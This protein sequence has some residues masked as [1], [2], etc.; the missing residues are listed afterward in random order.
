[1]AND[2]KQDTATEQP[3]TPQK[4]GS[5]AWL[6]VLLLIVIIGLAGWLGYRYVYQDLLATNQNLQQQSA[7]RQQQLEQLNNELQQLKQQQQRLPQ[8]IEQN[9]D[10]VANSLRRNV[11]DQAQELSD[12]QRAVQSVQAE[13]AALDVSQATAWRVLE[14]RHLVEQASHKL[15]IDQQPELAMQL[16]ELADSHLAALNNP[17]YQGIRQAINDDKLVLATINT[18]AHVDTAMALTSL[19]AQL[20]SQRWIVS[21]PSRTLSSTDVAAD[22]P[23]YT[24]LQASAQTLFNQL[25]RVQHRERPIEPQLSMAFVELTKQRVLLQLQ[26]AQ[27][28]ALTQSDQLYRDSISEAKH[29][30]AE[31][32]AQSDIDLS[33][34]QYQLARLAS[35]QL[36]AE[37]PAQLRSLPLINQKARA[38]TAG[39]TP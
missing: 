14:A 34:L 8:Q 36:Q 37:L 17:A 21:A 31:V 22:A 7:Q 15:Y 32:A 11:S 6:V 24:R 9:L 30:V 20:T 5:I 23:W 16:L 25:I 13:F 38:I 2:S 1:M 29:L 26:L 18:N 12:V 27:Q 3:D 19:R 33:A 35:P 4:K 39:A 28:A 10:Q